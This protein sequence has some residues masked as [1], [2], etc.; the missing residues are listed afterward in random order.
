MCCKVFSC[1]VHQTENNSVTRE[2]LFAQ[3]HKVVMKRE[4]FFSFT[5]RYVE[6]EQNSDRNRIERKSEKTS[7]LGEVS[8]YGCVTDFVWE[9]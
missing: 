9:S 7:G 8:F 3:S 6:I 1:Q 2:D 5:P 4:R